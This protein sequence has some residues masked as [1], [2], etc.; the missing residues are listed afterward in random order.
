MN[1]L[2]SRGYGFFLLLIT[3]G[4]IQARPELGPPS[5][6]LRSNLS[7]IIVAVPLSVNQNN[8]KAKIVFE[9]VRDLHNIEKKSKILLSTN[10][11]I[12]DGIKEGEKYILAYIAWETL[13]QP[14]VVRP[15][16]G[17]PLLINIAGAE[18]ALF[19]YSESLEKIL[20]WKM[21]SSLQSPEEMLPVL[22]QGIWADDMQARSFFMTEL[23]FRPKLYQWL[24]DSD[25]DIFTDMIENMNV[26]SSTLQ[27]LLSQ[28]YFLQKM[29]VDVS[30]L[31]NF[32]FGLLKHTVLDIGRNSRLSGLIRT[33]L[34][35]VKQC[36]LKDIKIVDR[37]VMSNSTNVVEM[38]LETL[39][40]LEPESV[41][42]AINRAFEQTLIDGDVYQVL[43]NYK[44]RIKPK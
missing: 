10:I 14:K 25:I 23:L 31:C 13:R 2:I 28:M 26:S 30:R 35:N 7:N 9:R 3:S 8:G 34:D 38:A 16:H 44:K 4:C 1:S 15:R 18:P 29:G 41:V 19:R 5:I 11:E 27:L 40:T 39:Y 32:Q 42:K 6:Q 21:E 17:G 20:T 22:M 36:S 33:A 43:I 12:S 24:S 37:W